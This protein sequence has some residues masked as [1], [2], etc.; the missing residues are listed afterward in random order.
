[1]EPKPKK[2]ANTK[3]ELPLAEKF[4]LTSTITTKKTCKKRDLPLPT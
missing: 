4:T 3:Q 1:L 2:F